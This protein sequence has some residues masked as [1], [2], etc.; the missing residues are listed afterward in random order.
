MKTR[1]QSSASIRCQGYIGRERM[2]NRRDVDKV[3]SAALAWLAYQEMDDSKKTVN[4]LADIEGDLREA[5][6]TLYDQ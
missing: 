5:I 4:E 1:S 2:M 3:A 6:R